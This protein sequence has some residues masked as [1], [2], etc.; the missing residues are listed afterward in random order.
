MN[1]NPYA[2]GAMRATPVLSTAQ[3]V[4]VA[5]QPWWSRTELPREFVE[6]G[7]QLED[8]SSASADES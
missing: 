7:R 2:E 8:Y 3:L 1:T 5:T 4:E 6:A